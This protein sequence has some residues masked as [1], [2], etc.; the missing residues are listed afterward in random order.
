MMTSLIVHANL[1]AQ[2]AL[3]SQVDV[4]NFCEQVNVKVRAVKHAYNATFTVTW[5]PHAHWSPL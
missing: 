3:Y 5:V 2:K 4:K 1:W